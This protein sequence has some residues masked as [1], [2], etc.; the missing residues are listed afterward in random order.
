[1]RSGLT[2]ELRD[3]GP[4]PA[5]D[6]ESVEPP[7]AQRRATSILP[8][9]LQAG[10]PSWIWLGVLIV[11]MGFVLIA[12]GWGQ[13]AAETQVYLQLPYVVSAGMVGLGL[14]LVGLTVL[15]LASRQRDG[16]E[17]DR[18]IDQLVGIIEELKETMAERQGGP[19]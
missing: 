19:R 12:V 17:R 1:M 7:V 9:Q 11:A 14:I 4:S 16:L 18:Q 15:N 13:V 5:M 6:V 2:R 3:A 8:P 10:A